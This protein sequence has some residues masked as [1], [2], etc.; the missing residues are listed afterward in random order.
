MALCD[1][2]RVYRHIRKLMSVLAKMHVT[3][4]VGSPAA[5]WGSRRKDLGGGE[6]K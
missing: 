6:A 2:R 1:L 5:F 4:T 3:R